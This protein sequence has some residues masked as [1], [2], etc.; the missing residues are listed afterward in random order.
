MLAPLTL[1]PRVGRSA[2][3][4][5]DS[6]ESAHVDFSHGLQD[7]CNKVSPLK[8][9]AFSFASSAPGERRGLQ[10]RRAGEAPGD[11]SLSPRAAVCRPLART[12][13]SL[14]RPLPWPRQ[15]MKCASEHDRPADEKGCRNKRSCA[16]L[17]AAS[18]RVYRRR[19]NRAT[20]KRGCRVWPFCNKTTSQ[21]ARKRSCGAS[22]WTF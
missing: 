15:S 20:R 1:Y 11:G 4:G 14:P 16:R 3:E 13:Q 10:Y 17:H 9:C 18:N 5:P 21:Y 22:C 6:K 7:L 2:F 12:S 8:R 19:K